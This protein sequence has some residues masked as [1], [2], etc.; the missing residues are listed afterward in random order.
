MCKWGSGCRFGPLKCTAAH[1]CTFERTPGGC[2]FG[3]A[4]KSIHG[5]AVTPRKTA[6]GA[7]GASGSSSRRT[8]VEVEVERRV[9]SH[10][11]RFVAQL[12]LDQSGSMA[13]GAMKSLKRA[14][15]DLLSCLDSE[16]HVG[17]LGFNT[18][19]QRHLPL[20]QVG[21]GSEWRA[22]VDGMAATGRTAL[23]DAI[24]MALDDMKAAGLASPSHQPRL[25]VLTDG[26]DT[27]SEPNPSTAL[28][29]L[30]AALA[31][32]GLPNFRVYI[33]A[34]GGECDMPALMSLTTLK[35]CELMHADNNDAVA[36]CFRRIKQEIVE[37]RR[38]VTRTVTTVTSTS[39]SGAGAGAGAGDRPG[40]GGAGP[41]KLDFH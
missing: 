1:M 30:Q 11:V 18:E 5:G 36:T 32:P 34:V 40:A 19:V 2:R 15:T 10:Q 24:R 38:T 14:A 13:G 7:G 17:V 41:A 37:L 39:M 9:V 3:D 23:W 6:P 12:V 16:D 26:R 27:S 33:I 31:H 28:K 22:A 29:E 8:E 4:C 25:V 21:H 20:G 35:H